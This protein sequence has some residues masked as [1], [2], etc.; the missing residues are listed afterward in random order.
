MLYNDYS[1]QIFWKET[2]YINAFHSQ[3]TTILPIVIACKTSKFYKESDEEIVY[4]SHVTAN[5]LMVICHDSLVCFKTD[6]EDITKELTEFK[7]V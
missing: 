2:T 1:T 3:K 4:Q 5:Y 6:S 7:R